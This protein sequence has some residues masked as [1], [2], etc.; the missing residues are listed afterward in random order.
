[1]ACYGCIN[2]N[3]AC[4]ECKRNM[5]WMDKRPPLPFYGPEDYHEG[6]DVDEAVADAEEAIDTWEKK[7]RKLSLF[8]KIRLALSTSGCRVKG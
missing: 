1:M 5:T 6:M 4:D 3:N 8:N 2:P 7:Y